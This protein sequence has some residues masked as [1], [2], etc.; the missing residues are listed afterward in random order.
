[1]KKIE[2]LLFLLYT[3]CF[4]IASAFYLADII[5]AIQFVLTVVFFGILYAISLIF[6]LEIYGEEETHGNEY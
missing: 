2:L 6:Y 3:F 1:M 4:G 5:P